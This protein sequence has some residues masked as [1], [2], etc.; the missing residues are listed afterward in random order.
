MGR[1]DVRRELLEAPGQVWD[2][3]P[4]C[5]TPSAKGCFARATNATFALI[6]M[7]PVR[8]S[9]V[10]RVTRASARGALR[11]SRTKERWKRTCANAQ[12]RATKSARSTPSFLRVLVFKR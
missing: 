6:A 5:R 12:P 10:Q 9:L 7:T 11:F 3:R 4:Y 2:G 8:V 1:Q